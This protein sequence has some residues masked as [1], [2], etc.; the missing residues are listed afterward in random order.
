[1]PFTV[2]RY[3]DAT[4]FLAAA[5]PFLMTREALHSMILGVARAQQRQAR[6]EAQPHRRR[7]PLYVTVRGPAGPML[8]GLTSAAHKFL[9]AGEAGA[10]DA[11][12]APLIDDLLASKTRPPSVFAEAALAA[13]FAQRWTAAT[14]QPH[15][16][17]VRQH[18]HALTAVIAPPPGPPGRLRPATVRESELLAEWL[19]AFQIEALPQEAGDRDA[20][21]IIVAGLL[22]RKDLF[23]WDTGQ[24]TARPVAMAARA[25]PTARGVAINLVYT[26][27]AERR[28]GYAS[29]LVAEL[30][31]LLLASGWQF[32]T[33]FTDQANPTANH[34]YAA[35]GYQPLADFVEYRFSRATSA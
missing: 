12:L 16:L 19:L 5:E 27:P 9:L 1:M 20:A 30:S 14:G 31:Q 28:H 33:L 34:I 22:A 17:A 11:A 10:A 23:V 25:R 29:A 24:E 18:L 26:P 35:I 15:A 6:V 4:D 13:A 8:A 21:Q 7:P 2:T 3:A 32:C